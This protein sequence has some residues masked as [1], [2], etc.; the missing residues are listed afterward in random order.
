MWYNMISNPK[1]YLKIMLIYNLERIFKARGIESPFSFFR[2][3]GFSERYSAKLKKGKVTGMKLETLEKLCEILNCT[4]HDL[5][6]WEPDKGSALR[7]DH[8]LSILESKN[9]PP[10]MLSFLGS[11]PLDR[12]NEIKNYFENES[13]KE[14]R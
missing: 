2:S 13:K 1:N 14:D 10:D 9:K 5:L 8:P 6:E 11:V 3:K 4:P 7:K 12:M